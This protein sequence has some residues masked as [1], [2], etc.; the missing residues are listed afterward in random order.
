M[1][2]ARSAAQA[3]QAQVEEVC[4]R[5]APGAKDQGILSKDPESLTWF[6]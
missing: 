6:K 2:A 4:R 3:A 5:V 1:G